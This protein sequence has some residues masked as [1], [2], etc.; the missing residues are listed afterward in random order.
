MFPF[1]SFLP[2]LYQFAV[3]PVFGD[4]V[5]TL[6]NPCNLAST[7]VLLQ[8]LSCASPQTQ[9]LCQKKQGEIDVRVALSRLGKFYFAR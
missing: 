2:N 1:Q 4:S 9:N 8:T 7:L 5:S 3:L 6:V